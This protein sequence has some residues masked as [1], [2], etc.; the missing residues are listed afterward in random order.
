MGPPPSGYSTFVTI[1][2]PTD[3]QLGAE[4]VAKLKP[5]NDLNVARMLAGTADMFDGAA[6]LVQAVF[7]A[8]ELR[9]WRNQ[10][11]AYQAYALSVIPGADK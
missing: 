6:G 11:R 5:A 8:K 7:Q 9:G 3:E 2:L 4:T 1:P 10:Q